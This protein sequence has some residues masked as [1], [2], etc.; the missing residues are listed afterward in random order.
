MK[1]TVCYCG[2]YNYKRDRL[3]CSEPYASLD[4]VMTR[5]TNT[6]LLWILSLT[7]DT[8]D[9]EPICFY[10]LCDYKRDMIHPV[11]YKQNINHYFPFVSN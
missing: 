4:H 11:H 2:P 8:V 9:Y 3:R 1:H 10:G 6:V 7:R 5:Q